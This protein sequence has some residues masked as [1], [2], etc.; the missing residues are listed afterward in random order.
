MTDANGLRGLGASSIV[1]CRGSLRGCGVES[2][3]DAATAAGFDGVSLYFEDVTSDPAHVRS[4]LDDRDLLA[5][6]EFFPRSGI[7]SFVDAAGRLRHAIATIAP[8]P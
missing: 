7:A 3:L 5:H 2:F 4:L 8:A 6:L 1:L